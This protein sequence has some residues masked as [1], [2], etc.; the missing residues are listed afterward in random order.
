MDKV[1]LRSC[2][3]NPSPVVSSNLGG[4]FEWSNG[5]KINGHT[6]SHDGRFH[7]KIR[8][9]PNFKTASDRLQT[10]N[11]TKRCALDVLASHPPYRVYVIQTIS[12]QGYSSRIPPVGPAA[13][14]SDK[15]RYVNFA[16][17]DGAALNGLKTGSPGLPILYGFSVRQRY[18]ISGCKF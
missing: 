6:S 12:P 5:R 10:A 7:E 17:R 9:H 2:F 15:A 3:K 8:S 18:E 1:E 14:G 4:V 13:S 16:G 11:Y